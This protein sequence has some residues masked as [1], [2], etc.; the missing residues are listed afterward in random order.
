MTS[1]TLLTTLTGDACR[2][3]ETIICED[4]EHATV[5][6]A[7]IH[8]GPDGRIVIEEITFRLPD[9]RLVSPAPVD[10][11]IGTAVDMRLDIYDD[12]LPGGHGWREATVAEDYAEE[13]EELTA[14][15]WH[16]EPDTLEEARL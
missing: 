3:L 15:P 11:E 1:N 12:H 16:P 8:V 2:H 6:S 5:S 9:G 14:A 7:S 10:G 13:L 4:L